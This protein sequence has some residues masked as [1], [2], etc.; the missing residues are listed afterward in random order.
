MT[1]E[2]KLYIFKV[3]SGISGET[4]KEETMAEYKQVSVTPETRDKID[5]IKGEFAKKGTPMQGPAIVGAAIN[6][7]AD[8]IAKKV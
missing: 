1:T 4:I 6:L 5:A 3:T 2:E 8:K 7:Y